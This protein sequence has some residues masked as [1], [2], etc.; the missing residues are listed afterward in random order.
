MQY[1]FKVALSN[2]Q[3]V[4][5]GISIMALQLNSFIETERDHELELVGH[6]RQ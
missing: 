3:R 5:L 1:L 6:L 2:G 4:K